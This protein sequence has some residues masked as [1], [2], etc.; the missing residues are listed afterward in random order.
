[1][2]LYIYVPRVALS[3]AHSFQLYPVDAYVE[4][5]YSMC[6]EWLA[7]KKYINAAPAHE[8]SLDIWSSTVP[9]PLAPK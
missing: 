1:M 6:V 9:Q 7:A 3:A 4:K 2:P 5:I 8:L